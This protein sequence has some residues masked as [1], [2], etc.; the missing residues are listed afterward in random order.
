M[1]DNPVILQILFSKRCF[2]TSISPVVLLALSF[3]P[4]SAQPPFPVPFPA[5]RTL[6]SDPDDFVEVQGMLF[7]TAD[8]S[9]HGRALWM[10]DGT[11]TGT[12]LV[13][14]IAPEV[15]GVA[16][17]PSNSPAPTAWS[18]S[19]PRIPSTGGSRG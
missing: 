11:E 13:Q 10:S 18:I 6:S 15:L 1:P 2:Y 17:I 5:T 8:D 9:V 19:M 12:G 3:E 7:F 16:P 14:D 4:L